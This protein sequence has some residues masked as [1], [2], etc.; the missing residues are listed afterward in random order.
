MKGKGKSSQ[1]ET[2][3]MELSSTLLMWFIVHSLCESLS[4][5]LRSAEVHQ[6]PNKTVRRNAGNLLANS[7]VDKFVAP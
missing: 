7:V 3:D 5:D 1:P 6:H 4:V 2:M